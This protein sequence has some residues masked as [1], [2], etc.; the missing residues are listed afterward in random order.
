MPPS[1]YP[2]AALRMGNLRRPDEFPMLARPREPVERMLSM[3]AMRSRFAALALP[4]FFALV[5]LSPSR[6]EAY[7]RQWHAG[8]GLGYALYMPGA[9]LPVTGSLHGAGAS[10]H[11]TYGISDTFNLMA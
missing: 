3:H 10:L 2:C 8:G 1:A 9:G 5:A 4:V 7:E 11:L 6:A